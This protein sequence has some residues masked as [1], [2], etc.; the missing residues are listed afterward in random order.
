MVGMVSHALRDQ[1]KGLVAD[2]APIVYLRSVSVSALRNAVTALE[3]G[4]LG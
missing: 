3:P 1:V 4:R 2:D